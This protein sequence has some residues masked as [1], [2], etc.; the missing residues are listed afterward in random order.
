MSETELPSARPPTPVALGSSPQEGCRMELT[1]MPAGAC[2][3]A[4]RALQRV[5]SDLSWASGSFWITSQHPWMMT[6]RRERGVSARRMSF[7]AEVRWASKFFFLL[8][9]I[10]QSFAPG[11]RSATWNCT[12]SLSLGSSEAQT[13][14][15]SQQQPL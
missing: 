5:N 3:G 4:I 8:L 11:R 12:S 14:C 2:P 6:K 13:F 7:G 1:K 10:S 9:Q 15:P